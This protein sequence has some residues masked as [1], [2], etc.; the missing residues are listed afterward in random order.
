VARL[1]DP[2][3]PRYLKIDETVIGDDVVDDLFG[4]LGRDWFFLDDEDDVFGLSGLD[5]VN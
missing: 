1:R 4:G 2:A 5:E 3:S